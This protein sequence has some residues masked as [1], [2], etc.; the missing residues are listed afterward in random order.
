[1]KRIALP[2]IGRARL[3]LALLAALSI[4]LLSPSPAKAGMT[5]TQSTCPVVISQPGEYS[6]AVDVG[7][8]LPG[9]DV[10]DITASGVTLHLNGRDAASTKQT[11]V[12]T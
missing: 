12:A 7:P 8:C 6:L 1:M 4:T 9:V 3:G 10:I 2:R 5:I 11:L